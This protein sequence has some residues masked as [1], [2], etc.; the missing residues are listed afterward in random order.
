MPS[1]SGGVPGCRGRGDWR[2]ARFF[3][4][5]SEITL[6]ARLARFSA[7][8]NALSA[9]LAFWLQWEGAAGRTFVPV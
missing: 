4:K 8:A 1:R 9:F 7:F 6:L 5:K 2:T 3:P